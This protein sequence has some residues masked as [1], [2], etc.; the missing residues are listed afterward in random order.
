LI[1]FTIQ[2]IKDFKHSG[3][4]FS[5]ITAYD[6]TSAQ[7]VDE[8]QIPLI[9][10]GDS[11]SMMVYGYDTTIP[12]TMKEMLLLV[13]AVT[14]GA[15]HSLVVADMPFLSYQPS[16][17]E[18]IYNAGLFLKEGRA[19]AVKIEGGVHIV[20]HV[21]ALVENG[22]PIL[23]H[24]GLTP[25]SYHQ[26]SGYKIQGKTPSD[27]QKII[28]D[29]IALQDA[30]AFG[31]VLECIPDELAQ[32]ITKKLTIPTIGIGSGNKCDGQIQVF[33][34]ILGYSASRAPRHAMQYDTMYTNVLKSIKKY[35]SD[36]EN[37]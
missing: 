27:A 20:K 33:H 23:G 32:K 24:I 10:V 19:S 11:A 30:G 1:K 7:I 2:H 6:Y 13:K 29:A 26:L 17:E 3:K 21:R 25:Q 31:V 14:R 5:T 12:I 8:A 36:I 34:D 37:K 28:G 15:K 16:I 35:K 9:L 18:T 4:P 22:I